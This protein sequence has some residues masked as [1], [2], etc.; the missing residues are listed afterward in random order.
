[1]RNKLQQR[2]SESESLLSEKS[3]DEDKKDAKDEKVEVR[4][5]SSKHNTRI[6]AEE[7]SSAE[8]DDEM[9]KDELAPKVFEVSPTTKYKLPKNSPAKEKLETVR[10]DAPPIVEEKSEVSEPEKVKEKPKSPIFS[11]TTSESETEID[12]QKI[13]TIHKEILEIT[14]QNQIKQEEVTTKTEEK[15]EVKPVEVSSQKDEE[16][17]SVVDKSVEFDA[18]SSDMDIEKIDDDRNK[19]VVQQP[20]PPPPPPKEQ[21]SPKVVEEKPKIEPEP[22]PPKIE[23]EPVVDEKKVEQKPP[24]TPPPENVPVIMEKKPPKTEVVQA[25]P[26]PPIP[27]VKTVV[28]AQNEIKPKEKDKEVSCKAQIAPKTEIK[29]KHEEKQRH[30][31]KPKPAEGPRRQRDHLGQDRLRDGRSQNYHHMPPQAQYNQWQWVCRGRSRFTTNTASA[32]TPRIRQCRS[33]FPRWRCC[34]SS[35]AARRRS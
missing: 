2:E 14:K 32:S 1:M 35:K 30:H 21:P 11:S 20:P 13:K 26:E 31:D 18:K 9:E 7:D 3:E 25:V 24:P 6:S 5:K 4:V 28:P 22:E 27:E 17:A 16:V 15:V 29:P 19:I 8:A 10:K 33:S 12:G 23:P 34:P